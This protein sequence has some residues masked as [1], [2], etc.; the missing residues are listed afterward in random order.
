MLIHLLKQIP[1]IMSELK[2]KHYILII[3]SLLI[4]Y[5]LFYYSENP[6]FFI[7]NNGKDPISIEFYVRGSIDSTIEDRLLAYNVFHAIIDIK[8]G[9]KTLEKFNIKK[10]I[11]KGSLIAS[12]KEDESINITYYKGIGKQNFDKTDLKYFFDRIVVKF[13]VNDSIV[14]TGEKSLQQL[15]GYSNLKFKI[16]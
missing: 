11:G 10:N 8:H 12:L 1:L 15:F 7:E 14:V 5:R 16:Q 2:I 13:S 6:D 9:D 4:L 3:V